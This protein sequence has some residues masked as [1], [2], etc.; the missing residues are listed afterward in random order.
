MQLKCDLFICLNEKCV[1]IWE[2]ID[3]LLLLFSY[4]HHFNF[5]HHKYPQFFLFILN[6]QMLTLTTIWNALYS[7]NGMDKKRNLNKISNTFLV[8]NLPLLELSSIE[9]NLLAITPLDDWVFL[10]IFIFIASLLLSRINLIFSAL[11]VIR[12]NNIQWFLFDTAD[13]RAHKQNQWI[14]LI[15]PDK[16]T[17][18]HTERTQIHLF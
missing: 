11:C 2:W 15:F 7:L 17:H 14:G 1:L 5:A 10:F 12:S 8:T 9:I 6:T 4:H 16:H 13:T 3:H 18:A